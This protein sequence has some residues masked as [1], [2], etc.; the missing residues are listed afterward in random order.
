ML[1]AWAP[2]SLVSDRT[3][4]LN[5]TLLQVKIL[6]SLHLLLDAAGAQSI[7]THLSKPLDVGQAVVES[8]ACCLTAS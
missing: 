7:R 8:A 6:L 5:L 1:P 2:I 4:H 3:V